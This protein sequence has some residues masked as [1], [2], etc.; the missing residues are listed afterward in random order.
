MR[1]RREYY[2]SPQL[3]LVPFVLVWGNVLLPMY[4]SKNRKRAERSQARSDREGD[5]RHWL[6]EGENGEDSLLLEFDPYLYV[7]DAQLHRI[8][9]SA[10]HEASGGDARPFA[11]YL[12]AS[13]ATGWH[14][15]TLSR[16]FRVSICASTEDPAQEIAA[17]YFAARLC[18]GEIPED[19]VGSCRLVL[20]TALEWEDL[21]HFV[22]AIRDL[23]QYLTSDGELC[24]VLPAYSEEGETFLRWRDGATP[25]SSFTGGGLFPLRPP[26][27]ATVTPLATVASGE[28]EQLSNF[29]KRHRDFF[30]RSVRGNFLQRMEEPDF[31]IGSRAVSPQLLEVCVLLWGAEEGSY[32]AFK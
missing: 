25:L 3:V 4:P 16:Y 9:A 20:S 29:L 24:L 32:S 6:G 8:I 7:A 27:S 28:T 22:A 2:N 1:M 23:Q 10:G 19:L 5:T 18:L 14:L 21:G 12:P 31:L 15:A 11:L 17:D 30:G 13:D 26:T